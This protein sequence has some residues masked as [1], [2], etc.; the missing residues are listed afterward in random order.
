MSESDPDTGGRLRALYLAEN[1]V[2]ARSV[3]S[4]K[5]ADYAAS[6][7]NYPAALFAMLK[8]IC[9]PAAETTVADIGSGTG[10]LTQDLLKQGYR[11]IA[12]EPNAEMRQVADSMLEGINGYRSVDGCAEK[13]PLAAAS[14]DLI[15]AAQAFH[16]FEVERAKIEFLRI[17]KPHGQVAL[18]WNDRALE[19][20]LQ[21]ALNE[22]FARF[23][24]AKR[25]AL[26]AH[27]DRAHVPQ[28]FGAGRP[29]EFSWPHE[30]QLT[31]EQFLSL[32]FSRSYIPGRKTP[33]GEEVETQLRTLFSR[34]AA[35]GM[36]RIRYR[37]ILFL[38]RPE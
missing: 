36:I 16:W 15:T 22:F 14:V 26:V 37:T 24:G 11:V 6:R 33:A 28:F 35:N 4:K 5:A 29:K 19:D 9:P 18:I 12:V 38:G 32:V 20:P 23:G 21:A 27:E 31:E 30:Q 17:L 34:F 2:G 8:S 13:I 7:P 1:G 10:L 3:F 25:A